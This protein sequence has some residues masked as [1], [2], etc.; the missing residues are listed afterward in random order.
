MTWRIVYIGQA[1]DPAFDQVLEEAEMDEIQAG[2]MKF[3]FEVSYFLY[4][5]SKKVLITRKYL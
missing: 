1:S 3:I 4:T 2:Q 5:N